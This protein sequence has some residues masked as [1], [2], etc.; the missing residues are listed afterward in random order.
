M[1]VIRFVDTAIRAVPEYLLARPVYFVLFVIYMLAI[2]G[3]TLWLAWRKAK[4]FEGTPEKALY[5]LGNIVACLFIYSIGAVFILADEIKVVNPEI[6]NNRFLIEMAVAASIYFILQALT[7]KGEMKQG[8][9][10]DRKSKATPG[11]VL[12]L[13][14]LFIGITMLF[15]FTDAMLVLQDW[16]F[17]LFGKRLGQWVF[18]GYLAVMLGCVFELIK[19]L[20]QIPFAILFSDPSSHIKQFVDED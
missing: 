5:M 18:N 12:F 6:I 17:S 9:A 10:S 2:A 20:A 19:S 11:G 16:G 14:M 13:G 3:L 7:V 8:T 15:I 1:D 4:M